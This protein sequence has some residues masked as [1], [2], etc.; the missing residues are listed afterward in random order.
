MEIKC[1]FEKCSVECKFF[2][3]CNLHEPTT[4]DLLLIKRELS[5]KVNRLNEVNRGINHFNSLLLQYNHNQLSD[6]ITKHFSKRIVETKLQKLYAERNE[7]TKEIKNYQTMERN[8]NKI[9]AKRC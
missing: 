6:F 3:M 8:I 1:N 7:L 4:F 5:W 2:S 9:L